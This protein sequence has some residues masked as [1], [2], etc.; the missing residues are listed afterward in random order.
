MFYAGIDGCGKY[1]KIAIIDENRKTLGRHSGAS[2]DLRRLAPASV[3]H[4]A[5]TLTREVFKLTGVS[6]K[7][8]A[9]LCFAA[10]A[11]VVKESG[12][13]IVKMFKNLGFACDVR[14]VC[15]ERAVLA[16]KTQGGPGV[17]LDAGADVVGYILN[18][19]MTERRIGGYGPAAETAGSACHIGKAAIRGVVRAFDGR[20]PETML[21]ALLL[22]HFGVKDVKEMLDTVNHAEYAAAKNAELMNEVKKAAAAGDAAALAIEK[23][24]AAGLSEF[25]LNLVNIYAPKAA[26]RV[27]FVMSGPILL[28]N[29]SINRQTAALLRISRPDIQIMQ[30]DEKP[31]YGAAVIA[32]VK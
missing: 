8:C 23:E 15:G 29:E 18:E 2:L 24:A 3:S 16:A 14:A 11:A 20:D 19:D 25:G 30:A 31:E 17:L 26:G 6:V 10:D 27:I 4:N 32:A 13:A 9:G 7:D 22:G 12:G 1:A 28:L 5:V 21:T